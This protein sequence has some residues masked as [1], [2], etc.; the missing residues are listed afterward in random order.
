MPN[1]HD[2]LTP[3]T[4]DASQDETN[5]GVALGTDELQAL[6]D[7]RDEAQAQYLRLL[8][9]FQTFRRRTEQEKLDL[10]KVAT[11]NLVVKLLPVLDNFERSLAAID[12]GVDLEHVR[13]GILMVEVQLRSALGSVELERVMSIGEA[14]DPVL[15][16]AIATDATA[17]FPPKTVTGEIEAGYRLAG[18]VI[19]PARVRIAQA[20]Q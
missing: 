3:P 18:K 5:R 13:Q 17:E 4:A 6:L 2:D 12:S 8:A 15:H 1:E 16:E 7:A 10:R 19:R 11:E 9:E 14:F 20:P